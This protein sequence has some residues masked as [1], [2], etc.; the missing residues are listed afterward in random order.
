LR[1]KFSLG[2]NLLPGRIPP[3]KIVAG[4][5]EIKHVST[6]YAECQNLTMRMS[7]GVWKRLQ[8]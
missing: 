7:I 5:P 1:A 6:S 3:E 2:L 8:F 4:N